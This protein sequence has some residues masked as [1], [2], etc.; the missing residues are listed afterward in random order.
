MI[1]PRPL[2]VSLIVFTLAAG[3]AQAS[4]YDDYDAGITAARKGQWATVLQKMTAALKGNAKESNN[5]RSYGNVF[6]NYHPYYY[7]GI[8]NLNLGNYEAAI[9]D[10]E[11]T[12]G[13]GELNLGPLELHLERSKEKLAAA[14]EAPAPEPPKPE[15]ARPTPAVTQ[16]T[17]PAPVPAAVVPQIDPTLRQRASA[18]LNIAKQKLQAAQQRRATG[19]QQY[20]QAMSMITDATTK[21]ASAR[22]NDDLNAIIAL[23]ESAADLAD[24]A[25]APAV[26]SA[27]APAPVVPKPVAATDVVFDDEKRVVRRALENYFAGEFDAATRDFLALSQR[28]PKNG[29]IWAFLGASQYSQYAFEADERYRDAA[30]QSFRQAKR[31]R[32]WKG[33]LPQ[34]YFSRRIRKAFSDTAG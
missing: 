1:R 5:A 19:S 13:P 10:L 2:A 14:N 31:L 20:T 12:S 29:W 26:A 17:A 9:S 34:K 16:T 22:N 4:W 25:T 3:V 6:I 24:L 21:N 27:P 32:S 33:G 11:K 8:A 23:A 18:A 15:P 7:R 28:L 30:L